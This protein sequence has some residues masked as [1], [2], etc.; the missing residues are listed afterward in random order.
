MPANLDSTHLEEV[1]WSEAKPVLLRAM[2]IPQELS[3]SGLDNWRE[4]VL[5]AA[6]AAFLIG[7]RSALRGVPDAE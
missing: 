5:L 3:G 7:W 2:P 1:A 4:L 6:K